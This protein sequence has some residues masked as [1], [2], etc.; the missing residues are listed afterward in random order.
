MLTPEARHLVKLADLDALEESARNAGDNIDVM[1][2]FED[3]FAAL[4]KRARGSMASIVSNYSAFR[5]RNDSPVVLLSSRNQ[6]A[7]HPCAQENAFGR[8][9]ARQQWVILCLVRP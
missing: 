2:S 6:S 8:R 3:I 4:D 9:S 1:G 5:K 7:F